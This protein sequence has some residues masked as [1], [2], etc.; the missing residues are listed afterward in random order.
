MYLTYIQ[1]VDENWPDED[2]KCLEY[3]HKI[4]SLKY[5]RQAYEEL[6]SEVFQQLNEQ[7]GMISACGFTL[8]EIK[9]ANLQ[10][11]NYGV[12]NETKKRRYIVFI[13]F[14]FR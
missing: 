13:I 12:F 2:K 3:F 5:L 4:R 9:H 8:D 1:D 11:I 6:G 10:L 14:L 7:F